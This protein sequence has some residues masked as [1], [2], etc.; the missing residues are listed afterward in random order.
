M[1]KY[2]S[3]A[4]IIL[5]AALV[6]VDCHADDLS[7]AMQAI[8]AF[9]IDNGL[10]L[11][12]YYATHV[13]EVQ[14]HYSPAKMAKLQKWQERL[15]LMDLKVDSNDDWNCVV[16]TLGSIRKAKAKEG[17]LSDD[18]PFKALLAIYAAGRNR[19]QV[20]GLFFLF[21]EELLLANSEAIL[22][23]L[24]KKSKTDTD[25]LLIKYAKEMTPA[26]LNKHAD[27]FN[28]AKEN[29]WFHIYNDAS[30]ETRVS[31]L[32]ANAAWGDEK[33]ARQLIDAFLHCPTSG[34]TCEY[35]YALLDAM[36]LLGSRD[37]LIAALSRFHEE[38]VMPSRSEPS[39]RYKILR[40]FQRL[41]PDDWFFMKYRPY[42][43]TRYDEGFPG[44]EKLGGLEG[45]KLLFADFQKWVKE[46]Y[47]Y[48]LDLSGA[49]CRINLNEPGEIFID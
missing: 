21:K 25:Y 22:E 28:Q 48:D 34:A 43:V 19:F 18:R 7:E 35:F 36:F 4:S 2:I 33:A 42:F 11:Q 17:K 47:G 38:N 41:C 49:S 30:L 15:P 26:I 20:F 24:I 39:V 1:R 10:C 32:A 31:L 5:I 44:D 40:G 23:P 16:S 13:D 45:V 3:L 8:K 6:A 9:L 46:R 29:N 14:S 12:E 27:F 37:A